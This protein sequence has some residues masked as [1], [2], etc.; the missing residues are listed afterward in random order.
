MPVFAQYD[1]PSILY[2]TNTVKETATN[3]GTVAG[4]LT[5]ALTGD[6]FNDSVMSDVYVGN[7]PYVKVLVLAL[8]ESAEVAQDKTS[9]FKD[10]TNPDWYYSYIKL[11][12]N[13]GLAKGDVY[14]YFYPNKEITRKE[15][16]A[17]LVRALQYRKSI[18]KSE[19]PENQLK[20]FKDTASLRDWSSN[21]IALSIENHLIEGYEDNTLRLERQITRAE[22]CVLVARLL[23]RLHDK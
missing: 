9:D 5:V 8:G 11:A 19:N 23:D 6:E 18:S 4:T 2:S 7:L 22:V 20:K 10:V 17:I 21:E 14:N 13:M 1:K 16:F 3:D 15:S 12:R